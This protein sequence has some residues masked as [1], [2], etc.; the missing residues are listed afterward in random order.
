MPT[1]KLQMI[2]PTGKVFEPY[3]EQ[4]EKKKVSDE[5]HDIGPIRP[6]TEVSIVEQE[7]KDEKVVFTVEHTQTS[8]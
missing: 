5:I 8:L 2:L 1:A 3:K 6:Q 4:T 7:S